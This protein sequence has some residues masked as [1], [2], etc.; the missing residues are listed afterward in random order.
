[1]P[2]KIVLLTG[3]AGSGKTTVA[4][5]MGCMGYNRLRFASTLKG[6]LAS[7]GLTHEEIDGNLKDKPC[8][9]L[10]GKTPRHA[11]QTLGTEWG[12]NLIDPDLWTRAWSETV[13]SLP[14]SI[15]VVVDDCRFP[16]EVAAAREVGDVSVFR[17]VREGCG[18][19]GPAG[20]HVS[21]KL[22]PFDYVVLNNSS[23]YEAATKVD[24]WSR[25]V[26]SSIRRAAA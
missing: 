13:R 20:E 8:E 2:R 4:M 14:A 18:L 9:F 1:M 19:R 16:N 12:R 15:N 7:L 3:Y 26:V 5:H 22:L 23:V 25:P 6:M 24:Q 11:M 17:L 10:G 21:E